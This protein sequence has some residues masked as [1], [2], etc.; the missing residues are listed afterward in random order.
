MKQ[1]Q[2]DKEK[3]NK[4]STEEKMDTIQYDIPGLTKIEGVG[5]GACGDGS[6]AGSC[7]NGPAADF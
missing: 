1:K 6:S 5:F 7:L 2:N 4:K 3:K